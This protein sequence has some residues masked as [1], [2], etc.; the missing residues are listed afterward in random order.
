MFKQYDHIVSL[1]PAASADACARRDVASARRESV[2]GRI[3]ERYF[4][5]GSSVFSPSRGDERTNERTLKGGATDD[6][7]SF[8]ICRFV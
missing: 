4:V 2:R 3:D 7:D 6:E 5:S 1:D 8:E